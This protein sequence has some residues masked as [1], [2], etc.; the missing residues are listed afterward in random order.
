MAKEVVAKYKALND[1][2]LSYFAD[3]KFTNQLCSNLNSSMTN[4]C[5]GPAL[6]KEFN[7]KSV[8]D[9]AAYCMNE[10]LRLK[11]KGD[12]LHLNNKDFLF[13]MSDSKYANFP[14]LNGSLIQD[15]S[16]LETLVTNSQIFLT[17]AHQIFA[18]KY[19]DALNQ[20]YQVISINV[21]LQGK[22][23]GNCIYLKQAIDDMETI[24]LINSDN[25]DY[26]VWFQFATK[27]KAL[28]V[29]ANTL[30]PKC[31]KNF[32]PAD[33]G[34]IAT[35]VQSFLSKLD[36]EKWVRLQIMVSKNKVMT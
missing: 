10:F 23:R 27:I 19:M 33:Y 26:G 21:E 29:I 36:K 34:D 28:K 14:A 1:S 12:L 2:L 18:Q 35:R 7:Q 6:C 9:K 25:P 30:R 11:G 15:A 17:S 4:A 5:S 24:Y 22:I 31:P 16:R 13:G 8:K 3:I 32:Q 20:E